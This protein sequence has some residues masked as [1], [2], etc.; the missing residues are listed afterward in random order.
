MS[1]WKKVDWRDTAV[2]LNWLDC[3]IGFDCMCGAK[4]FTMSD[5]SDDRTCDTCGRVYRLVV[6]FEVKEPPV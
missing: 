3:T 6:S 4:D 2:K 5:D 1:E